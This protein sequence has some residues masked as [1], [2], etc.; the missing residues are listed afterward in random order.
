LFSEP[1]TTTTGNLCMCVFLARHD[2]S[3]CVIV[4]DDFLLYLGFYVLSTTLS[5]FWIVLFPSSNWF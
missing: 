3:N 1:T 5:L 2:H 4:L